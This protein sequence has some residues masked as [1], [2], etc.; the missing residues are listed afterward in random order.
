ML[1]SKEKELSE[2]VEE[3]HSR[4]GRFYRIFSI[5]EI[6]PI[7]LVAAFLRLYQLNVTEFD[8]DQATVFR[9][10]RDAV[11]HGLLPA[12]SNIASIR[13][14][15]PPGVVYLLMLPAAFSSDPLWGAAL[16][17]LLNIAAVLLT[18]IFV[19][20]YFGRLAAIVAALFYATATM[21]V[22]FSRFMWQQNM[23]APFVVLFFFAL[24]RGV[25]DRRKGWLFPALLLLGLVI[26]LHETTALLAVPLLVAV[27]LAPETVRWRDV[28]F[29]LLA[30]LLLY[31]T[32]ILWE[33]ATHFADVPILLRLTKLPSQID[34]SA[35]VY[36]R[37]FFSPF[38]Q[39][40]TN[41][42]TIVYH[43][44]P[45]LSWL[46]ALLPLLVF[47]GFVTASLLFLAS[48]IT[49]P[50][51]ASGEALAKPGFWSRLWRWWTGFR[52]S[53]RRCAMLLLLVWQIVPLLAL[54]RHSVPVFPY[55]VLLLMPGPF[56]LIGLLVEEAS[57]WMRARG[58]DLLILRYGLYF[59]ISI[60]L[61]AQMVGTTAGLVDDTNGNTGHGFGYNSLSFMQN[62]L[63]EADQLARQRHLRHV[64]ISS[65]IRSQVSLRYLAEQ[66]RTPATVFDAASCLVLPNPATGPAV[67][68]V[69]PGDTLALTLLNKFAGVTQI[70]RPARLGSEPYHLLIVQ[71]P[72]PGVDSTSTQQFVNN[73]QLLYAHASVMQA[74]NSNML[75]T[76][77]TFLRSV[78]VAYRTFYTYRITASLQSSASGANTASVYSDC[79]FSSMQ[80]GDQFIVTF[81]FPSTASI[82]SQVKLTGSYYI[83][84]PH[85]V[86][87]GPL[88][89]E[90]I[91]DQR[92]APVP[93]QNSSGGNALILSP[94]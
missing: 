61:I 13:I 53:S 33:I 12:T 81:P 47:G 28:V 15:N 43:L 73:L 91:R 55:Y 7:L 30:N 38:S 84:Q 5:W 42:R 37:D 3:Q 70:D 25:V 19:R 29:G 10:A 87:M 88:Q 85:N 21:P 62:A 16:V 67:Y 45:A 46:N 71:S 93:L 77:W 58:R 8:E 82:S 41:P 48:F 36:Y 35:F 17:A 68:L 27:L 59:C 1:H 4:K 69:E 92:T 74:A 22:H 20:R 64:Y 14:N 60:T 78:P 54:S 39:A 18:Y 89:L 72:A 2:K 94:P 65:D 57:K 44:Y 11:M 32:Y 26:Q 63:N 50:L 51:S 79:V 86:A 90:N 23:I 80:A 6:Y 40:P 9:M 49:D 34:S 52:S 24:F 31:S 66:M 76:R 83:T 75:V 56:I